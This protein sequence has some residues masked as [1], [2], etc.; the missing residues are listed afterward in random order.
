M[1]LGAAPVQSAPAGLEAWSCPYRVV[2]YLPFIASPPTEH[3][4]RRRR[5]V[6]VGKRSAG[7]VG[8]EGEHTSLPLEMSSRRKISF[9]E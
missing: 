1:E 7:G 2:T 4:S 9:F 5:A 8:G 3:P 6:E